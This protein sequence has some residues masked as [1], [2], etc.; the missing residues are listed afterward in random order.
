MNI[1]IITPAPKN[2]L[3]GNRATA[4]RWA[5]ILQS[6]GHKV[7]IKTT[8]QNE[9]IDL[10][11]ALHAWR[12]AAA[13]EQF[14]AKFPNLP[15]I[16]GITGTDA[17]RFIH[18]HKLTTLKSIQSADYLVGLH[19]LIAETLPDNQ[20]YKMHVIKQ[21]AITFVNRIP[22][23][24]AFRV[25]V[26]GHLRNEKDSLRPAYAVRNLPNNSKIKIEHYGKAHTHDWAQNAKQ[27]MLTNSRYQWHGEVNFEG[28][29]NVYSKCKVL[30]LPSKME[31]GAN[32]ISEAIVAG[33]PIIAS[34]IHGSIGLLGSDYPGYYKVEDEESLKQVLL[35]AENDSAFY[36]QLEAAC[37]DLKKD[38]SEEIER[39]A[40]NNLLLK[41]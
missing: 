4:I 3:A 18:S 12:S 2:S 16:V 9:K 19:D 14:K 29:L 20:R 1:L 32:V 8:Y 41:I 36:T 23:T 38:F 24:S 31:G 7:E 30:V 13:V 10:M 5:R 22:D 33:I 37:I 21:S 34:N 35:K 25:C 40:W 28:M 6:L 11:I 26:V 17:Y 39:Q 15:L 27:E